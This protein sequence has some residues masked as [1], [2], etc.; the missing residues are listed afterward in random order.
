VG[1]LFSLGEKDPRRRRLADLAGR[2]QVRTLFLMGRDSGPDTFRYR[3]QRRLTGG[4]RGHR[5]EDAFGNS[6][7]LRP[8]PALDLARPR[9]QVRTLFPTGRDSERRAGVHHKGTKAPSRRTKFVDR[10]SGPDTFRHRGTKAINRRSPRSQRGTHSVTPP[11][12][13]LCALL[14]KVL[15]SNSRGQ[16]VRSGHFHDRRGAVG[17]SFPP[18]K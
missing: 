1:I 16:E 18:G 17:K 2:S 13:D 10:E 14:F 4:R 12:C 7:S 11:L 8:P 5:G 9:S 15:R 3:D 6:V